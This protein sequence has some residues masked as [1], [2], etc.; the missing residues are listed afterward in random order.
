MT[1]TDPRL[2]LLLED[3]QHLL[4]RGP[5]VCRE[6][7]EQA[8]ADEGG[9]GHVGPVLL[10]LLLRVLR[11]LE[12]EVGEP[13][14]HPAAAVHRGHELVRG[15]EGDGEAEVLGVV[16]RPLAPHDASGSFQPAHD[17]QTALR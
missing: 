2:D 7:L 12:G 11:A 9:E 15:A 17:L 6:L 13:G 1:F 3:D 4:L 5:V 16:A 10:H 8:L 14:E